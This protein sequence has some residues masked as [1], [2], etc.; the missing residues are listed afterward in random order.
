MIA[1][2]WIELAEEDARR[3]GVSDGDVVELSWASGRA[4]V[5]ALVSGIHEGHVHVPIEGIRGPLRV[6]ALNRVPEAAAAAH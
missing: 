1:E 6:R 2:P 3:I 4:R 5:A